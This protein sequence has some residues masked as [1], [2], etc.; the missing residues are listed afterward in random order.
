MNDLITEVASY[1]HKSK[2]DGRYYL[3][4]GYM[5]IPQDLIKRLLE[6][7]EKIRLDKR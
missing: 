7:A 1:Y 5:W 2:N 6:A 3:R 4:D